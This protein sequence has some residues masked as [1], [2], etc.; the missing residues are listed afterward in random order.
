MPDPGQ[1]QCPFCFD[2]RFV[3]SPERLPYGCNRCLGATANG[4]WAKTK[5]HLGFMLYCTHCHEQLDL[6]QRTCFCEE[7]LLPHGYPSGN[8]HT[9]GIIGNTYVG[10]SV[11]LTT[12][13]ETLKA[14]ANVLNL[15]VSEANAYTR[16]IYE[17]HYRDPLYN[18]QIL[19][20]ATRTAQM[21]GDDEFTITPLIFRIRFSTDTTEPVVLHLFFYDVSG[22]DLV[23][24][25]SLRDYLRF[26]EHCSAFIWLLSP[27][28]LALP[29]DYGISERDADTKIAPYR[30]VEL[31]IQHLEKQGRTKKELEQIPVAVCLN[32]LDLLQKRPELIHQQWLFEPLQYSPANPDGARYLK[33]LI[34]SEKSQIHD[35]IYSL[36]DSSGNA[37][38]WQHVRQIFPKHALFGIS[39]L[40]QAPVRNVKTGKQ[41]L[42]EPPNPNRVELPLLWL[43]HQLQLLP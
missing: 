15:S 20:D 31:I 21:T 1:F 35:F 17:K 7:N 34:A 41:R 4:W 27:A 39:S 19:P 11:Y 18:K 23:E 12:L 5:R 3:G 40:G 43:L 38:F 16:Q 22:E 6:R 30:T 14:K 10:K 28:N 2:Y 32:K 24:D 9:I 25:E 36:I 37:N 26:I 33:G 29:G 8:H 13:I 42:N